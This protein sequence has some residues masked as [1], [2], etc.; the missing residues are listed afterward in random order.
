MNN[1]IEHLLAT[2]ADDTDRP[3]K[4]D[5][6]DLLVRARRSVRRTRIAA[7]STAVLTTATIIGGV[8]VWS[9]GVPNTAQ[10]AGG[11]TNTVAI[12]PD[13]GKPIAPP[14]PVSPVS[15]REVIGRCM[16]KETE[17]NRAMHRDPASVAGGP[18]TFKWTVAV[19]S[20]DAHVLEAILVAP[21]S[22]VADVCYINSTPGSPS[23][24]GQRP[25][26]TQPPASGTVYRAGYIQ[27][28]RVP[29]EVTK[30]LVD[31]PGEPQVRQARMG[32]DGFYTL[33]VTPSRGPGSPPAPKTKPRIRGYAADGRKVLDRVLPFI[34]HG[35]PPVP[36]R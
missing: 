18:L 10:P 24:S 9:G 25:R 6:D 17:F 29:S 11:P 7:A 22:G 15:D 28:V 13:T 33:G 27:G 16:A 34:V 19:K 4:T 12:D 21:G 30:V 36:Q 8:A 32:A 23:W 35:M 1:D 31:V 14:P 2:A 5:V 3:L 20:S 26:L